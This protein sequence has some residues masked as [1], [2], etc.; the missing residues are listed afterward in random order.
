MMD[1]LI[2]VWEQRLQQLGVQ[3]RQV[4]PQAS[5]ELAGRSVGDRTIHPLHRLGSGILAGL[6]AVVLV[7]GAQKWLLDPLGRARG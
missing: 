4:A 2:V 7:L 1:E 3:R 6:A 5:I